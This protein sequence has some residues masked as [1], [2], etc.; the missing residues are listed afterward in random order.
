MEL[1]SVS[2]LQIAGQDD[3]KREVRGVVC[4]RR[5][6]ENE[7]LREIERLGRTYRCNFLPA[8]NEVYSS[9][10][11]VH[12]CTRVCYMTSKTALDSQF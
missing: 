12:K 2:V 10:K 5:K 11:V 1:K 4:V 3:M 8:L 9:A 7:D 6:A